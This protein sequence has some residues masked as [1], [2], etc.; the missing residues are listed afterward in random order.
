MR[1]GGFRLN[2]EATVSVTPLR[3]VFG[4]IGGLLSLVFGL[5]SVILVPL[6]LVL[7]V[8]FFMPLLPLAIV[9][10]LV[11]GLFRLMAPRTRTA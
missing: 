1:L 10:F 5:L 8:L 6:F 2:A 4:L 3:L 9:L 11:W 7:G